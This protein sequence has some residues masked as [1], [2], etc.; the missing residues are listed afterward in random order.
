MKKLTLATLIALGSL[1]C[2][3]YAAQLK[4]N[5]ST[6]PLSKL[7]GF[8]LNWGS[9][10]G[11]MKQ[12]P[13]S[14]ISGPVSIGFATNDSNG[15]LHWGGPT[16]PALTS[17]AIT[18]YIGNTGKSA[19]QFMLSFGGATNNDGWNSVFSM[20]DTQVNTLATN[21]AQTAKAAGVMGIDLDVD[22][23]KGGKDN[24]DRVF[25]EFI[26]DLK[27]ADPSLKIS[28]DLPNT[29]G[30]S[31]S[32]NNKMCTAFP[33][34]P[35]YGMYANIAKS[36]DSNV[37]W[38]NAM[39]YSWGITDPITAA[40]YTNDSVQSFI[41]DGISPSK[42]N[43]GV[44]VA[45]QD[46]KAAINPTFLSSVESY[47]TSKKLKGI[48]IY[49]FNDDATA[50]PGNSV[51]NQI[52]G[53]KPGPGPTPGPAKANQLIVH[54]TGTWAKVQCFLNTDWSGPETDLGQSN[55][56]VAIPNTAGGGKV[57][58]HPQTV[59]TYTGTSNGWTAKAGQCTQDPKTSAYTCPLS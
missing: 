30:C 29:G 59:N 52:T 42:I 43:L 12:A 46:D 28:I 33:N 51:I 3:S 17:S 10:A 44:D 14:N 7:S 57:F 45:E 15:G 48:F 27:K 23:L 31:S 21:L 34:S 54:Y 32:L 47:A 5:P 40:N 2:I 16:G 37:D 24:F 4:D 19:S 50:F 26:T 1:S 39:S 18:T 41:D 55:P 22:Q 6:Y 20:T 38:Y 9:G 8:T 53:T 49:S 56:T 58:C 13:Y 36:I 11:I 35:S 25:P